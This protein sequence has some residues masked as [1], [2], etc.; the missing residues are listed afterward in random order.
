MWCL[1]PGRRH[2]T[3]NHL[4]SDCLTA[5]HQNRMLANHLLT[6]HWCSDG[7]LAWTNPIAASECLFYCSAL[8][9]SRGRPRRSPP[10]RPCHSSPRRSPKSAQRNRAL[11]VHA[12]AGATG[13]SGGLIA[14]GLLTEVSWRLVFFFPVPIA[15]L[16]L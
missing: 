15:L 4:G 16:V 2:R 12:L 5:N 13:Y 11:G 3:S 8:R 10:R 7:D 1:P 9:C 6:N 14:S